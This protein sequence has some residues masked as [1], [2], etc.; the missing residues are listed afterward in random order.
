M[1]LNNDG[2]QGFGAKMGVNDEGS[3]IAGQLASS[4]P[5]TWLFVVP[6]AGQGPIDGPMHGVRA[7]PMPGTQPT[8]EDRV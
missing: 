4:A 1:I 8:P 7:G 3:C 2:S 6:G 5:V